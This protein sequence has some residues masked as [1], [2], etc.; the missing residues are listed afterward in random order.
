MGIVLRL[1]GQD[2]LAAGQAR[3]PVRLLRLGAAAQDQLGRDLAARA[4]RAH[5]D[6][7]ARQLLGHDDHRGLGQ[8]QAAEFLGDG[9][10]EDA[11]FG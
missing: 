10:A 5:A 2:R 6:I 9:Q 7:A 8:A 11:Q 4:K 1:H 3:Q